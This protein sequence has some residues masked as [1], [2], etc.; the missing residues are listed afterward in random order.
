MDGARIDWMLHLSAGNSVDRLDFVF[1]IRFELV[2]K[3]PE[4]SELFRE[5]KRI[6]D[7]LPPVDCVLCDTQFVQP[8]RT[9]ST[10][11]TGCNGGKVSQQEA[12]MN[13]PLHTMSTASNY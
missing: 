13:S 3:R 1:F 7:F 9:E 6:F 4:L 12:R 11:G 2:Y 5:S 8:V 10:V